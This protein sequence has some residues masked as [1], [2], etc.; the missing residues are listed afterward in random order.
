MGGRAN[1]LIRVLAGGQGRGGSMYC[2]ICNYGGLIYLG[3]PHVPAQCA[4]EGS[5]H[6]AKYTWTPKAPT[7]LR[8]L[9]QV[10]AAD[11]QAL[12]TRVFAAY[13][14]LM[15]KVQITY[16]CAPGSLAPAL[17]KRDI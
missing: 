10:T 14:A 3:S 5:W 6:A 8:E 15:R 2:C 1:L 13:L 12:V 17:A 4:L 11:Q 7:L 9:A 16:W